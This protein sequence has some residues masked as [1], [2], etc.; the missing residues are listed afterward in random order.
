MQHNCSSDKQIKHKH[1]KVVSQAGITIT[2]ID[3]IA[4]KQTNN[5]EYIIVSMQNKNFIALNMNLTV[6][7]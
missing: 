4:V 6:H 5:Y 3:I 2:V 1:H 7:Q